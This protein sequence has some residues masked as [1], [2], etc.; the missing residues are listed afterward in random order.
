MQL[1]II[2]LEANQRKWYDE[3][4]LFAKLLALALSVNWLTEN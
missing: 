4:L 2:Y 1:D 3:I